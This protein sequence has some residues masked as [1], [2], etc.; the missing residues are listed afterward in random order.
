MV[1]PYAHAGCGLYS[2]VSTISSASK[3]SAVPSRPEPAASADD[4]DSANK[5][6]PSIVGTWHE[7]WYSQGS[8][9]I[10]DGTEVDA[11]YAQW[12]S[13][14]TEM[15]VSGMRAPMT[16][17]VCVGEWIKTAKRTY[18]LNHFGVSYDSTG[19]I[20]VGPAVIRLWITIN[21]KGDATSGRFTI[22]QYDESGNLLAHLQGNVAGTRITMK[23][24]FEPVE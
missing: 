2:R 12:H 7:H 8:E 23:T 4:E 18:Q 1:A 10:P 6:D 17:D 14:G 15:Q 20:L 22:D 21:P 11:N 3:T 13:D 19:Q 5:A 24:G 16:G 9:G